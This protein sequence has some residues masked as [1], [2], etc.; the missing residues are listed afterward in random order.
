[1]IIQA[2]KSAPKTQ[3]PI[4]LQTA[5]GLPQ[6]NI[7]TPNE[8]G[9][10][11]N[12]Y[13]KFDVDTKGA[14]LNNSRTHVQTQQGGWVQ[15]NPYLARGE[16]KVILNEVN[17]S[18]PSVLKGY[19][20]VAG[21]KADVIIANPSG[22][23]CEGCG[24]INSDRTTFTTGKPQIQHGNLE[25]F[26]VEKG[27]VSVSGKG[28]DNSR[29]DYTEIIARETQINAGVWSKKEM[30]VVT[31]KNTVKR[32]G[33][34]EDLQIIHTNQATTQETKPQV[35]I[36]VGQLGGMYADKIH[37]IGTEQG[38]GV[39]NAGHIGANAETLKIDSQG[40]IVNS[41]T[42]NA[43][44]AV[45]LSGTKGIENRGKIENRQ[46]DITLNSKSDIKQDGVIVARAG[47]I[48]KT[49]DR[50]I[51]QQGE[52][53]AKGNIHY[54]A[55]SVTASTRSLIA[56]GADVKDTAEG[57][58]R[59]LENLSA[60]GK[61]IAI[62]S[63]GKATLQG[64]HLAS[65]QLNI[66]A[67]EVNLDHSRNQAYDIQVQA[68]QG[69]IQANEAWLAAQQ[70]LVLDTPTTLSTPNSHL[71][72]N[73]IRTKQTALNN[74]Y[75]VWLQTGAEDFKLSAQ[76]INNSG[77]T[78]S[79]QGHFFIDTQRV[80]NTKGKLI[81]A[82]KLE[83]DTHQGQFLS[84]SGLL[85]ANQ[86]L[87]LYTG[88]LDN[89]QGRIQGE[90]S[91]RIEA[92]NH[93]F[94]NQAGKLFTHGDLILNSAALS[95]AQG[96]I[97]ADGQLNIETAGSQLDNDKGIVSSGTELTLHSG[98][99]TNHQG[100]IRAQQA[101][102]QAALI[103]QSEGVIKADNALTVS[104]AKDL[105]SQENSL[106]E[107]GEVDLTIGGSFINN[108]QSDVVANRLINVT[109][110]DMDN[111]QG[112]IVSRGD[113]M[114]KMHRGRIRN[115]QGK[116]S[117]GG[118]TTVSAQD[119]I[120]TK[121]LVQSQGAIHL[122]LQGNLDN[123][124]TRP[125]SGT[126]LGIISL[127]NLS[128]RTE[129]LDNHLGYIAAG[130]NQSL[131]VR[132]LDNREGIVTAK[133]TQQIQAA[134]IIDNSQG[135]LSSGDSRLNA[136]EMINRKGQILVADQL[137][138]T[139]TQGVDNR[140]GDIKA[141]R[142]VTLLADRLDNQD[143][144][145]AATQGA[146]T[147]KITQALQ[148]LNGTINTKN[149]LNLTALGVN[150]TQGRV[151][152]EQ[153]EIQLNTR[154]E[155]FDNRNGKLLSGGLLA[156][157]AGAID[158]RAGF[159]QATG[160]ADITATDLNNSRVGA[161]GSAVI[162]HQYLRF[163]VSNIDNQATKAQQDNPTQGIIARELTVNSRQLNNQEGGIY[164]LSRAD[165]RLD[166]QLNNHQGEILSWGDLH[167][168][169]SP[170]S[171][172]VNNTQGILQANNK[173][174]LTARA[175]SE[176][177]HIE[178]G[179]I[180]INVQ[181]DVNT[182]RD[183]NAYHSLKLTT[184]G[185][186]V[187]QH[188]L[189]ANDR[190]QLQAGKITNH[191]SGRI[192]A[193]QTQVVSASTLHNE[194]LINSFNETENATTLI[195]A[196]QIDNIGTGR[197]YGDYV[198]LQ[199][200]SVLNKDQRGN[201]GKVY[202]ATIA[203]RKQLDIG[204]QRITNLTENYDA[205]RKS[206]ALIYSEGGIFFGNRLDEN[207]YAVGQALSLKNFSSI[208]EAGK[209]IGLNIKD[210]A[211]TNIH[212]QSAIQETSNVSVSKSYIL[213]DYLATGDSP[214][215][216]GKLS[217]IDTKGLRRVNFSR[218]WK[219]VRSYD[220]SRLQVITDSS[221]LTKDQLLAI[222]NTADCDKGE[223]R[224][225]PESVYGKDNPI[226]QYFNLT[227]PAEEMPTITPAMAEA[228]SRQKQE[229][230]S[231]LTPSNLSEEEINALDEQQDAQMDYAPIVPAKP[232]EP[233]R[234]NYPG[235]FAYRQAKNKYK[236]ELTAYNKAVQDKADYETLLPLIS[237]TA[238]YGDNLKALSDAIDK[239]N[240][241]LLGEEFY[242]FWE[243]FVNRERVEENITT[244]SLPA[245][246]LAGENIT[247]QSE[248][249]LNDK[250]WVISGRDIR[251]AGS[252]TLKN[253]DDEDAITRNIEEGWRD[254]TYTRWRGGFRRY[255]QRKHTQGG[256]LKRVDE[257][258]KDMGI[259]VQL[260]NTQPA[261][262]QHYQS[263]KSR[264]EIAKVQNGVNSTDI[265]KLNVSSVTNVDR[266]QNK[267]N[268]DNNTN[269]TKLSV[270]ELAV[271]RIPTID[272]DKGI[273]VRSI[274]VDTRLPT[275]SLYRINPNANSHVLIE[276][277]PDFAQY[278]KW[279][280]SD[281]MYKALR[282][283]H[284][285]VHKRLGDGYY[286]QRLVR[287]Q[288]NLLTGRQYLGGYQDFE[289]QYKGLMDAGI[290]F[291]KSFH[292]TPGVK[293][294]A[295]QVAALT[296]DIVWLEKEQVRLDDGSQTEVLVP[297]V[298][299][300]V[301]K[302]DVAGNGT[303]FSAHNVQVKTQELV[304][305]G[306][307]AGRRLVMLESQSVHNSGKVSGGTVAAQVSGD[308]HNIG[309]VFEADDAL[310]LNV[311]G[312]LAHQSTSK[313]TAV[314]LDGYRRH[315][316]NL[317]RQALL[318]VKGENGTLA[319]SANRINLL[320]AAIINE[321]KGETQVS[322]KTD[323]NLTA[324]SVGFDEKMGG[325]NHYRNE[326]KDDVEISRIKGGGDVRLAAKNIYSQ[327]ALLEAAQRLTALAQNDLVLDS[328][329]KAYELEEYHH[330]KS[331]S[332]ISKSSKTSFAAAKGEQ[333]QGS[334]L[335]GESITLVAGQDIHAQGATL[336][337][338][339]DIVLSAENNLTLGVSE[340]SHFATQWEKRKKSGFGASFSGGVA[341][342][343][344]QR[345]KENR[346]GQYD[347]STVNSTALVSQSGN[348]ELYAKQ[349][350]KGEGVLADAGKD[351]LVQGGN[352]AL[353]AAYNRLYSQHQSS[354][355]T[356]GVGV[357]VVYN[358]VKVAKANYG[359]QAG[360]GSA[361]G[362]VGKILTTAEA[363][364]KTGHQ[365]TS[366][367]SPYIKHQQ[368]KS[369]SHRA[370]QQAVVSELSAGGNLTITAAVGNIT[371]Q[372]ALLSAK[373]DGALWA[374]E[375]IDLNVAVNQESQ[376]SRK[377][378]WGA[379]L[380]LSK[381]LT[382]MATL[383]AGEG[384]GEGERYQEQAST[385]SFGGNASVTA[386]Q[387]DIRLVGTQFVSE[388]ESHLSAGKDI[389]LT[390]AQSRL[391]QSEDNRFQGIG[392][393]VISETE[394]FAGYNRKLNSQ[395]ADSVSHQGAMIA[396]LNKNLNINAGGD[397]H[398]TAGQLLAK[399]QINLQADNITFDTVINRQQSDSHQSDLKIGQ[400]A[401]V[402]SPLIDLIQTVESAVKNKDASDRVKAAQAL[403]LAAKGYTAYT[404]VAAGG[405]LIRVESGSGFSHKRENTDA[406]SEFS[407]GNSVN[408]RDIRITAT[409]GDIRAKQTDFTSRDSEGKRQ[410]DSRIQLN[411]YKDLILES[412]QSAEKFKGKQ[413]SAGFE[414]GVGFAVGAQ[415][416]L[417]IYAQAGF[418]QGK[419]E[420]RHVTQHNSHLD[421]AHLSLT[422]GGDTTLSGAV[423]KANRID[424]DIKGNLRIE[425]RQDEH[426][427]K[428]SSSGGGLRVQG[429]IG[430]AWGASGYANASSGKAQ[431][432]QVIEQSGL[433][434]EEGG[435][436][437][438]ADNV[439][440][441][442]AAI[443]STNA[444]NSELKTNKLTFED[445]Q[446]ES[447][448]RAISGGISGS[449]N[450]TKA[451]GNA[452]ITGAQAKQQSEF[453]KLTGTSQS[454]HLSPT[455]PMYDSE[456]DSSITKATL[457][458]GRITLNK[459]SAPRE[460]TAAELGINTDLTEAN[461]QVSAPKDIQKVLKEQQIISQNVGHM[462]AAATAFSDNR[463]KAAKE[464]ED[465]AAAEL[466]TAI[467]RN[468]TAS[469]E[470]KIAAYDEAKAENQRWQDGGS[471]RRKVD[472]AVAV[473]GA[474][475]S[476]KTAA[477]TAVAGLSPELNAKIH[478]LTQDNKAAN[479]FSHAVLSA[480]EFY[481]AGLDPAAG[482]LAGVAGEGV[483]MV[484]S[485]KVFNKLAEQLTTDERNLLKT[486]SQL[487]GAVV[488]GISGNSTTATLEGAATAKRAVENNNLALGVV[489]RATLPAVKLVCS[490]E[491]KT[492]L[493]LVGTAYLLSN[494][495]IEQTIEAGISADPTKI[496]KLS[497]EQREYLNNEILK[498][499]NAGL[500]LGNEVWIPNAS[501]GFT[502][503]DPSLVTTTY[504]G[505]QVIDPRIFV[506][507]TGGIEYP[508]DY[509]L[510]TNTGGSQTINP[511]KGSHILVGGESQIGDWRDNVLFARNKDTIEVAEKLGYK[512]RI[513]PQK[514]PF[515]SHGQPVYWN[516]KNYITPDVDGHN[517]TDGWKMFDRRGNRL[518]TFD[519]DLNR[520]KD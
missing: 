7:Q 481:A 308:M 487:A 349:T 24:V 175:F 74:A 439:H 463:A 30:K 360:Q 374:K 504:G 465:K 350:L 457:T 211:N 13:S 57:E 71:T 150:N 48:H 145:I 435:Y 333:Q 417:Y 137:H 160:D 328:V 112:Q 372:G 421:T 382:S 448:S 468:D 449:A 401:R 319:V 185:Q 500:F 377:R 176:D 241:P 311:K 14:I 341:A 8:Q 100:I 307:I 206:G 128:V 399:Q 242:R 343:G 203:A 364:G 106:I 506:N 94:N 70:N 400:F 217:Y 410:A 52:S 38:V 289:S 32:T 445:I 103:S 240:S 90:Q 45:Q 313:T 135:R 294:S 405:A 314:N 330:I 348:I 497:S 353:E 507:H 194:G 287:E 515:N 335:K 171:L 429:G 298:Y 391:G 254:Y 478:D 75:G 414:S 473:V 92:Y 290:T 365:L 396:S 186:L 138:L 109:A 172:D 262:Y 21:K 17:S 116:I 422:S 252:G 259:F 222:P 306:T 387:G 362:I 488:G 220:P 78:F 299:A 184:A 310:L 441:K 173:L 122:A 419:Q 274:P 151:T 248:R 231:R 393:A 369:N 148:N 229:G 346:Q 255:H 212:Y 219:Y 284:E 170:N 469:L 339:S 162:S 444:T 301:K 437:I 119:F 329:A 302:G 257:Q 179:H 472:A 323:L 471:S 378:N 159:I 355:K 320:G 432:K 143:G 29:V 380:D 455:V 166:S 388:G 54:N 331:G 402:S 336:Q 125:A 490:A 107:G 132:G 249:F 384:L 113:L 383:Y 406:M 269:Q 484:L 510:P 22:I 505:K 431:G 193:A 73:K 9:L 68:R 11:H 479:L 197:I 279:L 87:S 155:A 454:N 163:N 460:T 56:A 35:A 344:Y 42:L 88:Q 120:N 25:N 392:E 43:N 60:Q 373:G 411:A 53:I 351:I 246:I 450:L 258:H 182:K 438:N 268:F 489:K 304:N 277:D 199:A 31:G 379:G 495:E 165:F 178:A 433:F 334:E 136:M 361:G 66:N 225:M 271:E 264:N 204:A 183:I 174:N 89:R 126:P 190:L 317:D 157:S 356:S 424:T 423:A 347:S 436:H 228:I 5:N 65:G 370:S 443:A 149:S 415:T 33:K 251:N 502:A 354:R 418:T 139:A 214:Y 237:W 416:G 486:A 312:D 85:F 389:R 215:N 430:T 390:T 177:G 420:E 72:A 283:D 142:A 104:T 192:S 59:S 466:E 95:N 483:A 20:E 357:S 498:G 209:E 27:K 340:N 394:R 4:V 256:A 195:R 266:D 397:Y 345:S 147:L 118:N 499:G 511:D 3:Q 442:G 232:V 434:A 428:S 44:K 253:L 117:V 474:I 187:N 223:C 123:R 77:G 10:S 297:K 452:P 245:Q 456:Q 517:V 36:D 375:N 327:G 180:D 263:G 168:N 208:I 146:A 470:A 273:E 39:H 281:Y 181:S 15:G 191:Q 482:A 226:W 47:N 230:V 201:D 476:G 213:P 492:A 381:S 295:A 398:Q 167:I 513:P 477:Q 496:A 69:D 461:R 508:A 359:E 97:Q 51:T 152:T 275:Q 67:K 315:Q 243:L 216:N 81:A 133:T 98:N 61:T 485:E 292:L 367:F 296:T 233:K 425:S 291:A 55:P 238:K 516:G 386:Q 300:V 412:G 105:I 23:H 239:H 447:Q 96:N 376:A 37:L 164:S 18:D 462:I 395:N 458:E 16:A 86:T 46:G 234:E 207:N 338:Q 409:E 326:R 101:T 221:Q 265:G 227:A 276:T 491:C 102:I 493:G 272:K 260:E 49:A 459:D 236:R 270:T 99:L 514:A 426:L 141:S 342:L 82:G 371:T 282:H 19:V 134:T 408:A 321:G 1:M 12:K 154:G 93:S 121:G 413:Q 6:V 235:F 127:G 332:G 446:N 518:G 26:V 50:G 427:S 278:K 303:L 352:V 156:L 480:T 244:A 34:P 285:N 76:S 131:N 79:T 453:A 318:H 140:Q 250:S 322:A 451:M 124:Q 280:S 467:K 202:A 188:R 286:E 501:G 368:E 305:Q 358:P 407:L 91:V 247:Y 58:K 158:N 503:V 153:G 261:A 161:L 464:A 309:G 363:I 316:T 144:T 366:P 293:L 200:D 404:D 130:E 267:V 189:S 41:G 512:N 83:V 494:L 519:K 324:L 205:N 218:A 403:G 64:K 520:I 110:A 115:A 63:S 129:Q 196:K 325:G 84:S 169:G 40:R 114:M 337:A 2:D 28:L 108:G 475:L 80:D 288:I 440:L 385:L 62:N 509:N 198:A 224:I 111:Q 210:V